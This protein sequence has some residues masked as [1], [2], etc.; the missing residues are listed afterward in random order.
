M[1][2]FTS[3]TTATNLARLPRLLRIFRLARLFKL[4][5]MFRLMKVI[6]QWGDYTAANTFALVVKVITRIPNL[7]IS[8]L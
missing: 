3:E 2:A 4:L 6:S 5:R 8:H 1:L 7:R